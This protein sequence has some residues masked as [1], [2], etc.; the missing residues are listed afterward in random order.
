MKQK[1]RRKLACVLG[2]GQFGAGLAR[3]LARHCEVLAMDRDMARVNAISDDVQR[4][5]CLDARDYQALSAVVSSEFD[6]AVVS[7]GQGIEA[8]ILATLHLRR[9]G[10]R[11]IRVKA[12]SEDHAAILTSVGASQVVFPERETAERLALQMINPNLTD[13]IPL[14]EDYR[15]MDLTPPGHY[16]GRSLIDL[17]LR[18]R[19]GVFV[20]AIKQ[21]KTHGFEF[22]PQPSRVIAHADVLVLIGREA[23]LLALEEKPKT[24]R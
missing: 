5:L 8:S 13:L 15:V 16:L 2:L 6:E 22:L 3:A 19:H 10:V 17:Q 23:D 12:Q 7:V 14:A 18:A 9:I 24:N 21:P 4:A 20:I 1:P 11:T